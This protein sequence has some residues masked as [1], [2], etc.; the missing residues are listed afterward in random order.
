MVFTLHSWISFAQVASTAT[1]GA[2]LRSDMTMVMLASRFQLH[3]LYPECYRHGRY[4]KIPTCVQ[5]FTGPTFLRIISLV[6]VFLLP[7][8][9]RFSFV[10]N[11]IPTHCIPTLLFDRFLDISI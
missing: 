3:S 11:C 4:Q 5:C 7:N 6:H 8:L 1:T 2:Q 9:F 10:H